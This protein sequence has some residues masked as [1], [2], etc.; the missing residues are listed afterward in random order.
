MR[1]VAPCAGG[2]RHHRGRFAPGGLP[3]ALGTLRYKVKH[4]VTGL[5]RACG[6]AAGAE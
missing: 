3:V 2:W 5:D 6:R 1:H 4:I